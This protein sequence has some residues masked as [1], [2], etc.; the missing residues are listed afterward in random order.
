MQGVT[1]NHL[2]RFR[3]LPL[4]AFL[5]LRKL[6]EIRLSLLV[7]SFC[8]YL[9]ESNFSRKALNKQFVRVGLEVLM[10]ASFYSLLS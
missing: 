5:T 4:R 1:S 3:F 9:L 7:T 2:N 6:A 8:F 10:K